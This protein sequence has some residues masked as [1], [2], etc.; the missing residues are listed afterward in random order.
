MRMS[1]ITRRDTLK[2]LA[3]V[4]AGAT[5]G[6]REGSETSGPATTEPPVSEATAIVESIDPVLSSEPLGFLWKTRDPFLFCAHHD[7]RYPAGNEALGPAASLEGRNI[8]RDFRIRDGWRMYHGDVVPGFPR[9]PHRGFETVTVVRKGL[10]DHSDSMGAGARYGGGDVQWLTAGRGIQHAEMFPLLRRSGENPLELFQIWLNLP[11]VDKMVE[12]YFTMFWSHTI[13]QVREVD[14]Q[15]RATELGVI[16]GRHGGAAGPTP[17]PNSWARVPENDVGIWTVK[18]EPGA[19]WTLPAASPGTNRS[20]Y[21][22]AGSGIHVGGLP[23]RANHQFELVADR[24][25]PISNGGSP[26]EMLILQGRPIGEPVV[27]RGPFVMNTEAEIR[28]AQVDYGRTQ[29]GGW[30]WGRRDP[31][32]GREDGRFAR[33]A[34][35]RLERPPSA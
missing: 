28:Q 14:G 3:T 5:L 8:G 22:F 35:G 11:R 4:G 15:G 6:C 10:L 9:H 13:Q 12:P 18:M 2:L 17:P 19:S 27:K 7:D 25:L 34:D 26:S 21:L 30:P 33:H 31:V 29:F 24:P 16:A 1:E 32:H 20:L 23:L